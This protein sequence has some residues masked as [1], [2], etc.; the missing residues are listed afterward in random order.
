MH[1]VAV[2]SQQVLPLTNG[3][4]ASTGLAAA[5][6]A[7][8]GHGKP[9]VHVAPKADS[10]FMGVVDAGNVDFEQCMLDIQGKYPAILIRGNSPDDCK[11]LDEWAKKAMPQMPQM[12]TYLLGA[13]SRDKLSG[14]TYTVNYSDWDFPQTPH[15]EMSYSIERP[16]VLAFSCV[17]TGNTGQTFL[18]NT[19]GVLEDAMQR[20]N[21]RRYFE[22]GLLRV[23]RVFLKNYRWNM[24]MNSKEEALERM[25]KQGY[26][27]TEDG[28]TGSV[29]VSFVMRHEERD[30]N[31]KP[32]SG[33]LGN[34]DP[35]SDDKGGR[36]YMEK[37]MYEASL[38]LNKDLH[39]EYPHLDLEEYIKAGMKPDDDGDA[40]NSFTQTFLDANGSKIELLPEDCWE[41]AEIVRKHMEAIQWKEGDIV[42]IDNK[43]VMHGRLPRDPNVERDVR[44]A[45]VGAYQVETVKQAAE[46]AQTPSVQTLLNFGKDEP[47]ADRSQLTG[48]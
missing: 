46:G 42:V 32:L 14:N 19:V 15:T 25:R 10:T 6:T 5:V 3:S 34:F 1:R 28:D 12:P 4:G 21:L 13:A 35:L 29:W 45:L 7:A 40:G 22:S 24:S 27:L 9:S 20:P 8:K 39:K 16:H 33:F 48:A 41:L 36:G 18:V 17:K 23:D 43:R 31:G 44:V 30:A 11:C 37:I 26:Q 2:I 38:E 47:L